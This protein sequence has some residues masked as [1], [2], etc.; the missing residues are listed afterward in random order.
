MPKK[1]PGVYSDGHGGWYIKVSLGRD[2]VTG[3]RDQVTKR[4]FSSA[5]EAGQARRDLMSKLDKGELRPGGGGRTVNE[6]LSV[7]LDG[8]DADGRLSRKTRFDYRHY[9][10]HYVRPTSG[11]IKVRELTPE[12]PAGLATNPDPRRCHQTTEGQGRKRSLPPKG[13]SSNSIRLARSPLSG[14]LKLAV[15]LGMIANNPLPRFRAPAPSIDPEALVSRAGPKA[16]LDLMEGDRTW[17]IWAFLLGSGL[18]IGELVW[19]R[20]PTWTW[21]AA[22]CG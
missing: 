7:Y 16:F 4:G 9:A 13:L 12:T 1:E 18:R 19:L 3:K 11:G 15:Q 2:P 6:L 22:S 17:P 14:A 8:I 10:D 20:G 5:S 21:T